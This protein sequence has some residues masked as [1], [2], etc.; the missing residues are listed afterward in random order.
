MGAKLQT[1]L[2]DCFEKSPKHPSSHLP[3]TLS[4]K[5]IAPPEKKARFHKEKNLAT[6]LNEKIFAAKDSILFHSFSKNPNKR[7]SLQSFSVVRILGKGASG[8]VLLVKKCENS[9]K[10]S[11]LYAMKI[12]KKSQI[13][14]YDLEDHIKLEKH[15][16]QTN[17][18]RFL[19]KLKYAFQTMKNIYFIMEYMSGGDLHQLI[20]KNR[21]FPENLASFYAAE[22]LLALEYLHEKMQVIYRDLKPENVLLDGRGHLKLADF[23]LSKKT[24]EKATTFAGTPEYIAPEIL[25]SVGHSYSVDYWSLGIVLFEML[26]GKTPF[27]CYDGNFTTIVKLI[28]E[29]KPFFPVYFSV[30]A[31]D[32]IKKLLK[33]HPKERFGARGIFEIKNHAFFRKVNW[34]VMEQGKMNPPLNVEEETELSLQMDLP[35]KIQES[36]SSQIVLMNLSRITYNPDITQDGEGNRDTSMDKSMVGKSMDRSFLKSVYGKQTGQGK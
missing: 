17:R 10:N 16:L 22:I 3:V 20:K 25:L 29:N 23:G 15:I 35:S 5:G 6:N 11:R 33:S 8:K 7:I 2:C 30:E 12:I 13:Q 27:T 1:S 14:K 4:P 26:A 9:S 19:V 34:D 24:A 36:V 32:L 21:M 31:V 28:L 18:N